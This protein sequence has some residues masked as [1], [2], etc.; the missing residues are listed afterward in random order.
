MAEDNIVNVILVDFRGLDTL[1]EI[2]VLGIAALAVVGLIKMKK[3]KEA[4]IIMEIITSILAGV[5]FA[6]AIYNLLQKQLIRII[7]GTASYLSWCA[8][9]YFNDGTVKSWTTSNTKRRYFQLYGPVATG[10]DFNIHCN[11]LWCYKSPFG[12]SLSGFSRK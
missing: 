3:N 7:I 5:L 8:Y 10:T 1:F 11:Q 12:V 9:S 4:G 6:T 2:S